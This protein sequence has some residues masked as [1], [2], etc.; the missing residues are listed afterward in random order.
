MGNRKP[1]SPGVSLE[2]RS[3]L[4]FPEGQEG[5][6]ECHW[7]TQMA[8]RAQFSLRLVGYPSVAAGSSSVGPVSG[9]QQRCGGY[10]LQEF[11]VRHTRGCAK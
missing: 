10:G 5:T 1:L 7:Q 9:A 8:F 2:R 11:K 6:R 3:L 4:N